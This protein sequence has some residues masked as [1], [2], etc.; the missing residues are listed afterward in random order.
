MFGQ[1]PASDLEN[2]VWSNSTELKDY[3]QH[4]HCLS[5]EVFTALQWAF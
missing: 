2:I 1:I 4:N 5:R 3:Q